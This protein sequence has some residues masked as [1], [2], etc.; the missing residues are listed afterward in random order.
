MTPKVNKSQR[1]I[2]VAAAA[3]VLIDTDNGPAVNGTACE[4]MCAIAIMK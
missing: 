4:H 2:A 3:E 1:K